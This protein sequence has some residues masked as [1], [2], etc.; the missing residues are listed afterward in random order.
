M[1]VTQEESLKVSLNLVSTSENFWPQT[2][3]PINATISDVIV[4]LN[5]VGRLVMVV[6]DDGILEGT[7]TDGD[8][9]RGLLK[10]LDMNSPIVSIVHH[11]ALVVPPE[12]QRESVIQ[13]MEANNIQQVPIVDEHHHVIGLHLWKD[14]ATPSPRPNLMV[15]MAGG[16]GTRLRPDTENCPKPLL[17]IAGKPI[18]E[19]IIDRAKLEGFNHFLF[20]INY[21]GNMI[22]EYFSNGERFGVEIDYLR[23][24]TPL[25][26]A[27]ALSLIETIPEKPFIVNNGDV[28]SDIRYSELL[29]FHSRHKAVATMAVRSHE[30]EHPFG[31]V[32][33]QGVEIVGF[34]EKPT[35]RTH[36]NAGVYV[37]D[38]TALSELITAEQCDMPTLF[39]RLKSNAKQT[40]AYPMYEPWLDIGRPDDLEQA[41]TEE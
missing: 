30:W 36:I 40:V 17:Q 21:L 31:V 16:M 9:R 1:S 29:D 39:E 20:S 7:I 14:I 24:K 35:Y 5:K 25:G 32:P 19:H 6:N 34:E 41:N 27:G 12:L 38:P 10:G 3:L 8:L 26:T 37:L 2:I 13:L 11:D 23:E 15:I 22:E 18:L 28:I 33:T 4:N